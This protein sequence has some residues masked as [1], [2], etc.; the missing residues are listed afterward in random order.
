MD[1]QT[2]K[3][4]FYCNILY[5]VFDCYM[6]RTAPYIYVGCLFLFFTSLA[7]SGEK[8]PHKTKRSRAPV[9]T[10]VHHRAPP[11]VQTAVSA[12]L[13][14]SRG[15]LPAAA[16]P[17][18]VE[19]LH[20]STDDLAASL[21]DK[22]FSSKQTCL[23]YVA[24]EVANSGSMLM[25]AL[26]VSEE[27]FDLAILQT[28][29]LTMQFGAMHASLSASN[30]AQWTEIRVPAQDWEQALVSEASPVPSHL[31]W[32]AAILMRE[33]SKSLG[34]ASNAGFRLVTEPDGETGL[35]KI[36]AL[37]LLDYTDSEKQKI[38]QAVTWLNRDEKAGAY[39]DENGTDFEKL[40]WQSPVRFRR[41]SRGIGKSVTTQK[42][43]V[44]IKSKKPI[45]L[46]KKKKKTN[47]RIVTIRHHRQHIGVDFAAA[48]GTPVSA[49]AEARVAFM[50]WRGAYG[51]LVVLDHGGNYYTY[52]AHLSQFAEN[53]AVGQKLLRGE[54]LGLVGS[55]GRSTGPHLHFEI[56]QHGA[57]IDPLNDGYT[58]D[59]WHL[60]AEE[61]PTLLTTM[62]RMDL[63]RDK[64]LPR[65]SALEK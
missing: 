64:S 47:F 27:L 52:Y 8:K 16:L 9:I 62:L 7:W 12:G 28:N 24:A 43:R 53:L 26:P 25:L 30:R 44:P 51:N 10:D 42:Q 41:L 56:R 58:L 22:Q 21:S 17:L 15:C 5:R 60:Q 11:A 50:G 36:S 4:Y 59:I 13:H 61:L 46:A 23:H 37:E 14:F 18:L 65:V 35:E 20:L 45:K 31:I 34:N 33:M 3:N 38:L 57:Y 39:F 48:M 32:E 6:N 40:F 2:A 63:T 19:R 54:E 29:G 49:V 1:R 55:T